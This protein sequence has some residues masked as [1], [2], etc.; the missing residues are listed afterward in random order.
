MGCGRALNAFGGDQHA[1]DEAAGHM[2]HAAI[3][4]DPLGYARLAVDTYL[5]FWKNIPQLPEYLGRENGALQPLNSFNLEV[6]RASQWFHVDVAR[7]HEWNTLTRRYHIAARYWFIFLLISPVLSIAAWNFGPV[8]R[9]GLA[10][11]ASS[12]CLILVATCFGATETVYR[13]LHPFSFFGLA[14]LAVLAQRCNQ[15]TS[16][17]PS[18]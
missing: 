3:R 10:F 6:S 2:A 16:V 14:A 12:A 11:L 4:R 18:R 15:S 8:N 5:G 13:Y 7:Q 17:L 9:R 1:A